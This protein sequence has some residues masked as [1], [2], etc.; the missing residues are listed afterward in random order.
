MTEHPKTFRELVREGAHQQ[1]TSGILPEY[2]QTNVVILPSDWSED[3]REFARN[4]PKSIP[5]LEEM[6][7]GKTMPDMAEG[8]DIRTDIP[9]YRVYYPDGRMEKRIAITDIWQDDFVTF[10]IGCS[11]TFEHALAAEDI[12]LRHV[13]EKVTVPMYRTT[14]DTVPSGRFRGPVVVSMRPIPDHLIEKAVKIT[15]NF[16]SVHGGPIHIGQP[17]EI[18]I[19]H[20]QKPDYGEPVTINPGETP[21]FWGCG[22]TPQQAVLQASPPIAITHEPG[23]MFMTDIKHASYEKN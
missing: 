12:P 6:P 14:I 2:I 22:V 18:G 17:E 19:S 7:A 15:E 9:G 16:P 8:S 23:A 13:E 4:N 11:F 1:T 21:V 5:V 20:L 10:L 3:F